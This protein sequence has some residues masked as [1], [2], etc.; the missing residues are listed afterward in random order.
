MAQRSFDAYQTEVFGLRPTSVSR[1]LTSWTEDYYISGRL[2][3]FA[4]LNGSEVVT[5]T[6]MFDEINLDRGN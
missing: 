4:A 3:R 1:T 5:R 2:V 6:D